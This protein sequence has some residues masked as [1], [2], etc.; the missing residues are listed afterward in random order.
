MIHVTLPDHT[1]R[2]L[3]FYLAMEEFLAARDNDDYFFMWQVEPTVI[4]GRNQHILTEVN[5]SYCKEHGIDVVRRKSGGGCV[6]ADMNNVMFSYITTSDTVTTTFSRYTGMVADMLC[7]LG[8]DAHAGG[9]NDIIIGERKVSG[10]A[11]YH[12]RHRAILHGTMLYDTDLSAMLKAITPSH[13]KLTSKGVESVRSRVINIK[14][15][16]D[17]SLSEFKKSAASILCDSQIE[18]TPDDIRAIQEI[19]L[20][21]RDPRWLNGNSPKA[22]STSSRHIDGVGQLDI[23]LSLRADV[24]EDIDIMGDFFLLSD[25]DTMIL[26]RLRGV[27]YTRQE[28][29]TAMTGI[30]TSAVIAGLS[31]Q[32]FIETII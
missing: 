4:I 5:L 31:T 7:R 28:I 9:R 29:E 23:S 8:I 22:T 24:I 21:Y 3:P 19:E 32:Q 30:D 14:E 10:N 12:K 20:T 25:I 17:I 27:R 6:Y 11:F 15:V 2:P 16:S 1:P 13:V 18:L 26:D